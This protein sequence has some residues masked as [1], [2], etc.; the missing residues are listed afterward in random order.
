MSTVPFNRGEHNFR[1][2][3]QMNQWTTG[4]TI[5][6]LI[7]PYYQRLNNRMRKQGF[8]IKYK[9]WSHVYF[10]V[11]LH[12]LQEMSEETSK[13]HCIN[14]LSKL[15]SN[16]PQTDCCKELNLIIKIISQ[17]SPALKI[18]TERLKLKTESP[19]LEVREF[20]FQNDL[21]QCCHSLQKSP[22]L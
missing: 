3:F 15:N 6:E 8:L 9:S 11:G 13:S 1:M 12:K 21:S 4:K 19:A 14:L 17:E 5:F 18:S 16:L 20:M 7:L 10:L 22:L 2:K